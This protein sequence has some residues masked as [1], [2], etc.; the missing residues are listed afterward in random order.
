[1]LV[2]LKRVNTTAPL[3]VKFEDFIN[4]LKMDK[5]DVTTL[6]EFKRNSRVG[7]MIEFNGM[8]VYRI[9]QAKAK[10]LKDLL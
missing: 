1:M 9:H 4:F 2:L 8:E 7:E 6:N 10:Q 5:I 3:L